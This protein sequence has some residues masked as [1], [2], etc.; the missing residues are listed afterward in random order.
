MTE[1]ARKSSVLFKAL[2]VP[3][4]AVLCTVAGV[5]IGSVFTRAAASKAKDQS[6]APPPVEDRSTNVQVIPLAPGPIEELIVLPCSLEPAADITLASELSGRIDSVGAEEG[7][8]VSKG[9]VIATCDV[10]THQASRDEAAAAKRLAELTVERLTRLQQEGFTPAQELDKAKTDLET[11]EAAL[12]LAEIQLDKAVIRS[13]IDGIMDRRYF[14]AGEYANPGQTVARIV[15]IAQVKA[16]VALPETHVAFVHPGAQIE[17]RFP[18]LDGSVPA[19][20]GPVK[21]L[22]TVAD[23]KSRTY[24]M[25][26]KLDNSDRAMRPGMIGKVYLKRRQ[27]PDAI[28]VPIFSVIAKEGRRVVAVEEDG[29]ARIRDVSLGITDGLRVQVLSGL[30]AGDRLIVA[31]HRELQDGDPVKVRDVLSLQ[32]TTAPGDL[33]PMAEGH[34]AP[35][36]TTASP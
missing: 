13:P 14:D 6:A 35:T 27:V 3:I 26:I 31:G 22:A 34:A 7:D 32:R 18:Y 10:R 9:Q 17:V 8:L 20:T 15:D 1:S 28:S 30:R 29:V 25:E 12:R 2:F 16:V 24:C 21:Y 11:R 23:P 5:F 33:K 36:Q 19:M 4:L